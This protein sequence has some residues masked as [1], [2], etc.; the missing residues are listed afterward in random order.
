MTNIPT[1]KVCI[2][3]PYK[4]GKTTLVS[5]METGTFESNIAS[6]IA[7]NFSCITLNYGQ[8]PMII[9]LWDTA[10]QEKYASIAPIYLRGAHLVLCTESYDH[11]GDCG[12][13][14][15]SVLGGIDRLWV[16]TKTDLKGINK[17]R[18]DA[19]A[20]ASGRRML[21]RRFDGYDAQVSARTG[22]GVEELKFMIYEKLRMMTTPYSI[23]NNTDLVSKKRG[24]KK[25]CC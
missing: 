2:I 18:D 8:G 24:D 23:P 25:S 12:L 5:R 15:E 4:C 6:T 7:A 9:H 19:L 22:E 1:Y 11:F 16:L 13:F 20:S 3:G 14:D 21:S 10:G 17:E